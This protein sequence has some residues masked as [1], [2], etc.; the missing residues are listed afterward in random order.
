M[1]GSATG[2]HA[3]S[4]EHAFSSR[5]IYGAGFDN[6]EPLAAEVRRMVESTRLCD[7]R[8]TILRRPWLKIL[9]VNHTLDPVEGGGTAG[10]TFRMSRHLAGQAF[11]AR[12]CPLIWG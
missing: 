10:R 2:R 6:V 1:L 9:N 4:S 5:K 3:L 12:S 11:A 7:G 8:E